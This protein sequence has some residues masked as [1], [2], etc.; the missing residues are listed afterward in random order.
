MHFLIKKFEIEF[1]N[2]IVG[3]EY[4]KK[5]AYCFYLKHKNNVLLKGY[6]V[7]YASSIS[8]FFLVLAVIMH[9]RVDS[10]V[11]VTLCSRASEP[12]DTI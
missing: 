3:F 5:Y 12:L 9:C 8:F 4:F 6:K 7:K 1:I 10:G 2:L 11:V